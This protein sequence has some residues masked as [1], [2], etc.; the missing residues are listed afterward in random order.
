MNEFER[1]LERTLLAR[2]ETVVAGQRLS[3]DAVVA[4]GRSAHRRRRTAAAAIVAAAVAVIV[5]AGVLAQ[6]R[7]L[8]A[9][10]V[11]PGS[12]SPSA[13]DTPPAPVP[14]GSVGVSLMGYDRIVTPEGT[15]V[16]LR[17]PKGFGSIQTV[18]VPDGW[19]LLLNGV[20][21]REEVTQ[22]WFQSGDGDAV[23]VGDLMSYFEVSRDG[24]RVAT[25]D[26]DLGTMAVYE[27]PSLRRLA[28]VSAPTENAYV[29][30]IGGD[31]VVMAESVATWR[32]SRAHAW[33][34]VTGEVI[35]THAGVEVWGVSRDGQVLRRVADGAS[36]A[37][38]DLVPIGQVGRDAGGWCTA[39]LAEDGMR[40]A[41][42]PSGGWVMLHDYRDGRDHRY[43]VGVADIRVGAGR[44]VPIAIRIGLESGFF[45]DTD[46]SFV[47]SSKSGETY[48]CQPVR[49]CQPLI[50]PQTQGSL[51]LF[52]SVG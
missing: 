15:S 9:T 30:G 2:A 6:T 48:R 33:N 22:V 37:C 24:R 32:E 39:E 38:V 49:P 47:V 25:H 4:A 3:G 26:G 10:P 36:K 40:G 19:V 28:R 41:L 43:W 17:G 16:P 18:R 34:I 11:P 12:A 29:A 27:L 44:P 13:V 14:F 21:N 35:S 46:S 8:G 31:W 20:A 42:A 1:R 45:W 50:V 7:D 5:G 52:G 51:T 23:R